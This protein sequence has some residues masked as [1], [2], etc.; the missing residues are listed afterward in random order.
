MKCILP[1]LFFLVIGITTSIALAS[2]ATNPPL[3]NE[4]LKMESKDQ[5]AR[6]KAMSGEI[7][8]QAVME[9]DAA[10]TARM[11][12]IVSEYG[13]PTREL[14]GQ[15]GASAAWLL[16]QH[17]D[18]DSEF[19]KMVLELMEPFLES[20]QVNKRE[21]AYLWDRTHRPQRYGTQ[22]TC[23]DG[24]F[25]PREIESPETVDARRKKMGMMPLAEYIETASDFLNASENEWCKESNEEKGD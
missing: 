16:V 9:I 18:A 17:S 20:G 1:V 13:W 8:P 6:K 7:E 11:K 12:E 25:H 23:V 10:N 14:V 19:Q 22:G 3:R 2:A 24:K 4:L 21:Y 15:D 5:A